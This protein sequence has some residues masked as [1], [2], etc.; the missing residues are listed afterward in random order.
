MRYNLLSVLFGIVMGFTMSLLWMWVSRL[1][2]ITESRVAANPSLMNK[3]YD[4]IWRPL[5]PVIFMFISFIFPLDAYEFFLTK[6]RKVLSPL[7]NYYLFSFVISLA[8]FIFILI[9]LRKIKTKRTY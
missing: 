8:L 5:F 3:F 2:D 1:K 4:G 6:D 7:V 9:K